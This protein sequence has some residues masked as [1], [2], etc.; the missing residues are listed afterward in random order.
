MN[1]DTTPTPADAAADA[2]G[3]SLEPAAPAPTVA[4]PTATEPTEVVTPEVAESATEPVTDVPTA[5]PSA[6][7]LIVETATAT[8]ATAAAA[9]AAEEP[10]PAPAAPGPRPASNA[11]ASSSAPDRARGKRRP[12]RSRREVVLAPEDFERLPVPDE[13]LKFNALLEAEKAARSREKKD[14]KAADARDKLIADAEKTKTDAAAEVRRLT[15]AT[16]ATREAKDAADQAYKLAVA[17]VTAIKEGREPEPAP[18]AEVADDAETSGELD[19]HATD[20]T[21]AH[22]AEPAPD[23]QTGDEPDTD[24]PSGEPAEPTSEPEPAPEPQAEPEP[25]SESE[26]DG[27]DGAPESSAD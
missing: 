16:D 25:A 17:N 15:N 14:K 9:V 23:E 27:A 5:L 13:L 20:E 7:E 19:E 21:G 24:E 1:D 2:G 18:G 22:D 12:G 26:P 8:D 3:D 6:P 10:T 4:E 11:V